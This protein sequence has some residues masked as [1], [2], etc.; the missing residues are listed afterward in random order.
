MSGQATHEKFASM[1]IEAE[2]RGLRCVMFTITLPDWF[3][4]LRHGLLNDCHNG[5]TPRDGQLWLL[6]RWAS[7]RAALNGAGY[8]TYGLRLVEPH[9]DAT[10]H[11]VVLMFMNDTSGMYLT[12]LV[13]RYM[14]QS[15]GRVVS[16]T[17][18]GAVTGIRR[19]EELLDKKGE[20]K[21]WG[22]AWGIRQYSFFGVPD[23][24]GAAK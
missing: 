9:L 11:W 13:K 8:K 1:A 20:N 7:L 14:G 19:A 12:S 4:P 17:L 21:A 3:H 2:V 18:L 6:K 16:G 22:D 23:E 15:G 10:P 24:V 5:E